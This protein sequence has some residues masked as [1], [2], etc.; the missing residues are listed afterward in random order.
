MVEFYRSFDE[1][2]VAIF[3]DESV[4]AGRDGEIGGRGFPP[5]LFASRGG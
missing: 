2:A 3:K 4:L 1:L 5:P